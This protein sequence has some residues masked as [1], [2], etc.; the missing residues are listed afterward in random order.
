MVLQ[1][2]GN[3]VIITYS[4]TSLTHRQSPPHP[5]LHSLTHSLTNPR[6]HSLTNPRTHSLA[7]SHTHSLTHSLTHP[8][9]QTLNLKPHLVMGRRDVNRFTTSMSAD[10][11]VY[12]GTDKRVYFMHLRNALP[13]EAVS[14]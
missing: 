13:S 14:E 9:T 12:A 2:E 4:L 8:L 3:I 1:V 7:P 11:R 6:T 5:P 10:M